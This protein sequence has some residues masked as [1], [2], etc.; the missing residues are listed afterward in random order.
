MG[1]GI[2]DDP[3]N[4]GDFTDDHKIPYGDAADDL[5]FY[6]PDTPWVGDNGLAGAAT[7]GYERSGDHDN[8]PY[9]KFFDW[10]DTCR[11]PTA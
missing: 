10:F 2:P 7:A 4:V 11:A 1:E 5:A 3:T 6:Y 8:S 9:F